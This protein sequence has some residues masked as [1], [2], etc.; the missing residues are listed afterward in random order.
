MMGRY[1]EALEEFTKAREAGRHSPAELTF[2]DAFTLSRVGRYREAQAQISQGLEEASSQNNLEGRLVL[3][4]LSAQIAIERANYAEVTTALRGAPDEVAQ[5]TQA[6]QRDSIALLVELLAGAAEARRG[7]LEAARAHLEKQRE[8]HD[9]AVFGR[10][11]RFQNLRGEIALA[12]GDLALAEAAFLEAEPESKMLFSLGAGTF[13]YFFNNN[14]F[15]DG[16]ARVKKAQGDL[17]GA[18]R[19]YRKLI[20]P[21]I[22]SKYTS[23]LEPRFVLE[24]A[25]LLDESGQKD[26][27]RAEYERFLELWKDADEGLPELEEAQKYTGG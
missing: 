17:A 1:D 14:P 20:T 6:N 16:P 19:M 26:A 7:N 25:R 22:S 10:N 24:L 4:C 8:M 21:D 9:R 12:S 11:F 15:I 18:I 27:A 23:M 5:I 2:F 13:A 3:E